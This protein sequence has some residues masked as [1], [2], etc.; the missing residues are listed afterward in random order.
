MGVALIIMNSTI[1]I[2]KRLLGILLQND[3]LMDYQD[4]IEIDYFCQVDFKWF[5][6]TIFNFHKKNG[7]RPSV[8]NLQIIILDS[9]ATPDEQQ[10]KIKI[11]K[12]LSESSVDKNEIVFLI[13]KIKKHYLI[14]NLHAALDDTLTDISIDN[15]ENKYM[16]LKG[17][18]ETSLVKASDINIVREKVNYLSCVSSYL[19]KIKNDEKGIPS[20]IR[21]LDELIG[22]WRKNELIFIAAPSGEGKS[23]V[24]LNFTR[25]AFQSGSNVLYI[26]LELSRDETIERYSSLLSSIN[27]QDIRNKHLSSTTFLQMMFKTLKEFIDPCDLSFFANSFR[28]EFKNLNNKEAISSFM[29]RF[30]KRANTLN[31]VDIPRNCTLKM[32]ERELL[33]AINEHP[34]DLL[35]LDH[36]N[37]LIADKWTKDYWLDLGSMSRDLKGIAKQYR[38][39]ILSAIQLKLAKEGEELSQEHVRYSKMIMDNSDFILGFSR[40]Q[41]DKILNRI[42]IELIKH[43]ATKKEEIILKEDFEKMNLSDY[44]EETGEI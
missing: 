19:D 20:G 1:L 39:P 9:F 30:K 35:V 36:Y 11:L 21:K 3:I 43:R 22:G 2:E 42:R 17:K 25:N 13:E 29:S 16:Q 31:I 44:I 23:A 18:L 15:I 28:S 8:E 27:Y 14:R 33:K 10:R 5:Y 37:L 40:S 41:E 34:V 12:L 38:I 24:L 4:K 32:L 26:T 6:E 7:Y